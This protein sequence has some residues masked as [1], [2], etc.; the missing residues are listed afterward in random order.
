MNAS[1]RIICVMSLS[2][3]SPFYKRA[4]FW[5]G[6]LIQST[7]LVVVY[8]GLQVWQSRHAMT[9]QAPPINALLLSGEQVSLADYKGKP[10]LVHFW[11]SWCPVCRF[12]ETNIS[13]IA[14]DHAVLTFAS[15]SGDANEVRAY[16]KQR[17]LQFPIIEDELGEWAQLYEVRGYPSSFIIAA[18]GSIYDVEVGYSSEWGLRLRLFLAG[19]ML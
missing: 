8:V 16:S 13:A 6:V 17:D 4:G 1:T 11:A 5:R 15:Q 18:D 3:S 14:E 10:M 7:L 19:L 2:R 9:G 12:E